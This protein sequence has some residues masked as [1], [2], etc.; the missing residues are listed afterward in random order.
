LEAASLDA[1]AQQG[2]GGFASIEPPPSV[3]VKSRRDY[4]RDLLDTAYEKMLSAIFV[5]QVRFVRKH[6][7]GITLHFHDGSR[8]EDKGDRVTAHGTADASIIASRF[9]ELALAHGWPGIVV[10]GS[11]EVI[12]ATYKLALARGLSVTCIDANQVHLLSLAQQ[13]GGSPPAS[14]LPAPSTAPVPPPPPPTNPLAG[15]TGLSGIGGRLGQTRSSGGTQGGPTPPPP[16]I[17]KNRWPR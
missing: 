4:K 15:L 13:S 9:V 7:H 5:D 12:L 8:L 17:P 6:A 3:D 14:V 16:R 2:I 10:R 11:D 1:E